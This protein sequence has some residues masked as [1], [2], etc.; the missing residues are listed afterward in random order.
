[1]GVYLLRPGQA[2]EYPDTSPAL[3]G[4]APNWSPD[5]GKLL[6]SSNISRPNG[7][8]Y[9]IRP[10]GQELQQLTYPKFPQDDWLAT[11]SPDGARIVFVSDR[12]YPD[13]CCS[14]LFTMRADDTH[15]KGEQHL[16]IQRI[17]LPPLGPG[18]PRWGTA[19]LLSET[20]MSVTLSQ[21]VPQTH[22]M[23]VRDMCRVA[24]LLD[25]TPLC[26]K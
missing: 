11:Y 8:I 1:M 14:D 24:L 17:P 15:Y 26:H 10:D 23:S 3:E 12:R 5:G 6:V 21:S 19:P 4:S 22:A 9:S 25:R 18:N 13:R 20:T 16:Q 2:P 7:A